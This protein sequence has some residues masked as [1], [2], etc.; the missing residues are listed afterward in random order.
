MLCNLVM[1]LVFAMGLVF[2]YRIGINFW[3]W[4]GFGSVIGIHFWNW[5]GFGYGIVL[6]KILH[7]LFHS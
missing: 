2:G 4:C 7:K 3:N 5:C 1:K 6:P